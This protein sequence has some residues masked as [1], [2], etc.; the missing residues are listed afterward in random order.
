MKSGLF[1]KG[2]R[3][4]P[5]AHSLGGGTKVFYV[6]IAA[7]AWAAFSPSA[8][9]QIA[10]LDKGHQLIVN[11]GL[12]IWG[13]QSDTQ[14]PLDYNELSAANMNGVMF[15]YGASNAGTLSAGQKWGKWVQPRQNQSNYTS[16]ANS[17]DATELAHQN[18]LVAIQVGDEQQSDIEDPTG[19]TKAWFDAAHGA[20]LYTYQLMYVNSYYISAD[21]TNYANFIS[22]V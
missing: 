1:S 3:P 17:L 21:G 6:V 19:F 9:A 16:P 22:N 18:D 10:T 4:L 2:V 20:N 14:Y 8:D 11:Q 7:I 15:S 12:Q 13:L 5:D